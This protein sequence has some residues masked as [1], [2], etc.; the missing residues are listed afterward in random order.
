MDGYPLGLIPH[1][2]E[3]FHLPPSDFF[4]F[5]LCRECIPRRVQHPVTIKDFPTEAASML[6]AWSDFQGVRVR[7]MHGHAANMT[8]RTI[9]SQN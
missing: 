8:R 3:I 9:R 5:S 2:N 6:G 7:G 1:L 4:G